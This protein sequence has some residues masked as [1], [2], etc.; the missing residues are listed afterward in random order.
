MAERMKSVVR[1]VKSHITFF[2]FCFRVKTLPHKDF[3]IMFWTM[4]WV[5]I[6]QSQKPVRLFYF[7]I[8]FYFCCKITQLLTRVKVNLT[9]ER[10]CKMLHHSFCGTFTSHWDFIP[11]WKACECSQRRLYFLFLSHHVV[12]RT[13]WLLLGPNLEWKV[14]VF[15]SM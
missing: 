7:L 4:L 2:L 11:R 10:K 9:T 12:F 8:S 14:A 3:W 6:S 13:R 15:Y 5:V 1:C